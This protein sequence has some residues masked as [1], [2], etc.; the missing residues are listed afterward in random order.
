MWEVVSL[1]PY[2]IIGFPVCLVFSPPISPLEHR[3]KKLLLWPLFSFL[4]IATFSLCQELLTPIAL[5]AE[6][7]FRSLV[8][9]PRYIS[10]L[11]NKVIKST[12]PI[13]RYHM[14]KQ[15]KKKIFFEHQIRQSLRSRAISWNG[16]DLF[17][18]IKNIG[19]THVPTNS[20]CWSN[21]AFTNSTLG[22]KTQLGTNSWVIQCQLAL[23]PVPPE[24][25][26]HLSRLSELKAQERPK[27]APRL[28]HSLELTAPFLS[29]FWALCIQV[30]PFFF[31]HFVLIV[32]LSP[33][34]DCELPE[35]KGACCA[36][37][38]CFPRAWH[39]GPSIWLGSR[40]TPHSREASS[41]NK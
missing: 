26:L 15:T 29:Y 38:L 12:T 35:D 16:I 40:L 18:F 2:P 11:P 28:I 41:L 10:P 21:A 3:M 19:Q 36:P 7:L 39:T 23:Q 6:T 9:D 4:W 22:L 37:R 5:S 30:C 1:L 27:V 25:C 14:K 20:Q 31:H 33:A 32:G 13:H 34:L 24:W 8:P 17:T